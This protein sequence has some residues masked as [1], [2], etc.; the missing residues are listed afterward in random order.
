MTE[1]RD[2]QGQE[3]HGPQTNIDGDVHGPVLSGVFNAP[4][5]LRNFLDERVFKRLGLEQRAG[6]ILLAL[7]IIGVG[8]GL[9][10]MLKTPQPT[11]MAGDFRIAVAQFAVKGNSKK[12]NLGMELAQ[13]IYIRLEENFSDMNLDFKVTI[14][15]PDSIESIVNDNRDRRAEKAMEI[16]DDIGA[17]MIVYGLIDTTDTYW[18]VT[19]EFFV[20]A[21]NFY[22]AEEVIG[23]YEIGN[24][25]SVIGTGGTATRIALN[26]NLS[27]KVA[28]LSRITV[29]LTRYSL[30]DFDRAWETFET[31][32][33][34]EDCEDK[35]V[36]QVLYLL[37]GNAAGKVSNLEMSEKYHQRALELDPEYARAYVGL[38]S[39]HYIRSLERFQETKEPADIDTDLLRHAIDV[40]EQALDAQNKPAFSD[41]STKVHFGLGQCYTMLV[42]AG[43]EKFF[44]SAVAEYEAV[45]AAYGQGANPRVKD[46]AA[47]AHARLGLIYNLSGAPGLSAEEYETAASLLEDYPERQ[48]LYADRAQEVLTD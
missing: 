1:H 5:I 3:I 26:D 6:F 7:L 9:Y 45:I 39:V 30:H 34:A 47:E 33:T 28:T 24:P 8:L 32:L 36:E 35:G 29:G 12:S 22:N 27:P 23:Q 25:F 11:R 44:D 37:M 18:T 16:A 4:I 2:Q 10:F 13:D 31:A 20:S 38:A 42:Y 17:D 46:L 40:Y 21:D 14:W 43:E 41:I 15:G 19:P 48:Q